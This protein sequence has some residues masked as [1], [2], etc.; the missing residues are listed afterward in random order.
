MKVTI[1][2]CG[3]SGG[4]PGVGHYWGKCNPNDPRN[5]RLR[6]SIFIEHEKA[7]LLVDT[8]PDLRQQLLSLSYEKLDAVLYTHAH[9][10]HLNGIDDLRG[11]NRQF[12][13]ELPMFCSAEAY[14][15]IQNRFSYVLDPLP[16][17]C[18]YF[19]KPVLNATIIKPLQKFCINGL[20]VLSL[21]QDHG[22][23]ESTGYRIDDF[24]Y[25]TDVVSFS[26]ESFDALV[27]VKTWV[28]GCLTDKPHTTHAHVEKV[29]EWV[30]QLKPERTYLTHL[31][32]ELDYE[33]LSNQ[34]PEGV[35][36]CFDGLEIFTS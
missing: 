25:C 32:T 3:P 7:S 19:Y 5:K 1:L 13:K 22:Y 12:G 29:L 28:V 27:G 15:Q 6:P 23:S 35:F 34:L 30:A 14:Q 26:E 31:G 17:D 11:V 16:V 21:L 9:A 20:E 33:D 8:S 18:D 24:A 2:G 4:V 36:A 10:D